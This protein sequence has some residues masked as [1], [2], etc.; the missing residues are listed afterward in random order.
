MNPRERGR[1]VGNRVRPLLPTSASTAPCNSKA[2][3]EALAEARIRLEAVG[4]NCAYALHGELDPHATLLGSA[5]LA[6]RA[7]LHLSAAE[8]AL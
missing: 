5:G 8:A 7:L 6:E 2:T 4:C 3:L 1:P